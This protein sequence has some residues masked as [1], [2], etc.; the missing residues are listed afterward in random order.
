MSMA[1]AMP[2]TESLPGPRPGGPPPPGGSAPMSTTAAPS[3]VAT[4]AVLAGG[5]GALTV[6]LE[7]QLAHWLARRAHLP[8]RRG[9]R[10]P[11]RVGV[12]RARDR[13]PIRRQLGADRRGAAAPGRAAMEVVR[14]TRADPA[15]LP[16]RHGRGPAVPP[17]V[18][19]GRDDARLLRRRG[20]LADEPAAS[21]RRCDPRPRSPAQSI[22]PVLRP[23]RPARPAGA[24]PTSDKGLGA[25]DPAR[26]HPTLGAGHG[27][28]GRGDQDRAA[29][30]LPAD[31]AVPR[32]RP[33]GRAPH[34]LD[35]RTAR[36]LGE[37]S[38]TIR[39]LRAMWQPWTSEIAADV[40]RLRA[41]P[42]TPRSPRS[43]TWSAT[44]RTILR[45]PLGDPHPI[46]WL[47]T[48]L[49]C[50]LCRHV[51]GT[52][53]VGRARAGD[54]TAH[55]ATHAEATT[56]AAAARSQARMPQIAAAA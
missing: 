39:A 28:P 42:A 31:L 51:Y 10:L 3:A 22:E 26:R 25:L 45:W 44:Q 17:P 18:R 9:V 35:R 1:T 27:N 6:D 12:G 5:P 23:A 2:P 47:R 55:P 53:T 33:P 43:T 37:P 48:L 30:P 8:R 24:R 56:A 20:E 4:P 38:P 49:G 50:A 7:R 52:R 54:V 14:A 19:P 13:T 11:R 21:R 29:Q 32:D 46:G 41:T 15:R 34:R 16:R 40:Y 36:A